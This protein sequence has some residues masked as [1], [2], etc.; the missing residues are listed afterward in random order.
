MIN[1]H[2]ITITIGFEP[3]YAYDAP[4]ISS[5]VPLANL[6]TLSYAIDRI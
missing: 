2:I 3:I 4:L 6:D 5:Q 1:H